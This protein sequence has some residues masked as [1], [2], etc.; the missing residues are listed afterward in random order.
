MAARAARKIETPA[1]PAVEAEGAV[2]A[3]ATTVAQLKQ[4][5]AEAKALRESF[6]PKRAA[7]AY[8]ALAGNEQAQAAL[9]VLAI[10]EANTFR[11]VEDIEAAIEEARRLVDA[12]RRV[13]D[14]TNS[15]DKLDEAKEFGREL[16]EIDESL[17]KDF[18]GIR[19]KID[20]RD[21][22]I[23]RLIGTN[24]LPPIARLGFGDS[25][26]V[27]SA[28]RAAGLHGTLR[29]DPSAGSSQF[30]RDSKLADVDR[31]TVSKLELPSAVKKMRPIF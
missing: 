28:I 5:L 14:D 25:D 10:E 2:E 31:A 18:A 7:L 17:D 30:C 6:K 4:R 8:Q 13:E 15:A 23:A 20:R 24:C 29:V 3:A 9:E 16:L 1:R 27:D 12:A 19:S 11:Q 26:R 21:V 22:V